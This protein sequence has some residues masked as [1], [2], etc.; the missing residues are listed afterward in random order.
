MLVNV[1][2]HTI[3]LQHIKTIYAWNEIS[4][5]L[6]MIKNNTCIVFSLLVL[7]Q[8]FDF[9]HLFTFFLNSAIMKF[10]IFHFFRKF[11][12]ERL[13]PFPSFYFFPFPSIFF[14]FFSF[15]SVFCRFP[16]N[17]LKIFRFR[18][19]PTAL[20]YLNKGNIKF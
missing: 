1:R 10:A 17:F 6:K 4:N 18:V 11:Y 14:S 2:M 13:I 15:F 7:L 19:L 12:S 8:I 9:D 5:V 20:Y 3:H 16:L